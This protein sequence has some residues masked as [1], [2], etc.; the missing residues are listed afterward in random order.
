MALSRHFDR[1]VSVELSPKLHAIAVRN[2][3]GRRNIELL[4]GDSAKVL[5]GILATLQQPALFWLDAHY[6][7][8]VTALGDTVSPISEELDLV[9]GHAV[10]GHVI[11][12]DDAREFHDSVQ[13]GYPSV[14]VVA[15]AAHQHN[16]T[17]TES[18]DIFV[19]LPG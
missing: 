7:E 9:L 13:S 14:E 11:L 8:G 19:L 6:S 1:V 10:K 4:L 18:E 2:T 3:A 15:A 16:Y 17:M 12:I 5:P